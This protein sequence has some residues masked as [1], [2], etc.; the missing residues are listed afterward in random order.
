MKKRKR[1]KCPYDKSKVSQTS[2]ILGKPFCQN[3]YKNQPWVMQILPDQ[4][5]TA[6]L[7]KRKIYQFC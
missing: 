1:E 7:I 6:V 4:V 5:T 3:M 2:R